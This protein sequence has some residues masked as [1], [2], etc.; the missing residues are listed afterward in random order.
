[1]S[2]TSVKTTVN[3]S[4]LP[5]TEVKQVVTTTCPHSFAATSTVSTVC[6][7]ATESKPSTSLVGSST[8]GAKIVNTE[9]QST[10]I[11]EKKLDIIF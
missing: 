8:T 10:E 5:C 6:T 7:N 2:D 4:N 1:M 11:V 9:T 3:S